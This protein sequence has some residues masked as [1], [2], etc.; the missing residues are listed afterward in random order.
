[1]TRGVEVA[2]DVGAVVVRSV[3]RGGVRADVRMVKGVLVMLVL[4]RSVMAE[5]VAVTWHIASIAGTGRQ[6]VL[7][8]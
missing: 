5:G 1:M 8:T 2:G 4:C 3:E 7:L 6:G